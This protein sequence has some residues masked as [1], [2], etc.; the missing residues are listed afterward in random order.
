MTSIFSLLKKFKLD[1][2]P[3]IV[4]SISTAHLKEHVVLEKKNKEISK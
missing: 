2:L 3:Y 4:E 1:G